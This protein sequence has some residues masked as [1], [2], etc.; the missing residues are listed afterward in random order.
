MKRFFLMLPPIC[1]FTIFII[2]L[3]IKLCPQTTFQALQFSID[4]DGA[5]QT[6][7]CWRDEHDTFYYVFLPSYADLQTISVSW[8]GSINLSNQLYKDEEYLRNIATNEPYEIQLRNHSGKILNQGT[9]VFVKSSNIPA[10]YIQTQSGT[11]EYVRKDKTHKESGTCMIINP[12]GSTEY[13]GILNYIKGR[14]NNTWNHSEK[15]PY[16]I[17]LSEPAEL[18]GM[19][20]SSSWCLLSNPHDTSYLRNKIVY[21]FSKRIGLNKAPDSTFVDLY[22]NNEYSGLYLLAQDV[23]E[24]EERLGLN[25]NYLLELTPEDRISPDDIVIK[26]ISGNHYVITSLQSITNEEYNPLSNNLES[27]ENAVYSESGFND[28]GQYYTEF[29]DM[30]SWSKKYLIEQIFAN[31]DSAYASQYFYTSINSKKKVFHAGPVWDYDLSMGTFYGMYPYITGPEYFKPLGWVYTALLTHPDFS[32]KVKADF[33]YIYPNL[34]EVVEIKLPTYKDLIS[35]STDMNHIRWK[36]R[37]FNDGY[38][39]VLQYLK[40]RTDFLYRFLSTG[41]SYCHIALTYNSDISPYTVYHNHGV[42]AGEIF[43]DFPEITREGCI[44]SGWFYQGTDIRFD[45]LKPIT[46]DVKLYAKWETD[47]EAAQNDK[48]SSMINKLKI[49][50]SL[51]LGYFFTGLLAIFML[52]MVWIEIRRN[53]KVNQWE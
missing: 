26:T 1:L 11:M 16:K 8:D 40:R 18:I 50:K 39:A 52:M 34:V 48:L 47:A 19:S 3:D 53:Y 24:T 45:S 36:T 6:I 42:K 49:N 27:F 41:D 21:D 2:F 25:S 33:K 44:F 9:L 7:P 23:E 12:D 30:D 31:S 38:Q 15:K 14:G 10:L 51:Y 22:L 5:V 20:R 43:Y 37:D 17:K 4:T 35:S 29:I 28:S 32:E 46:S 13:H